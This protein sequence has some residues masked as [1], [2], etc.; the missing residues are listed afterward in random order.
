MAMIPPLDSRGLLPCGIHEAT[1]AEVQARF[2]YNPQRLRLIENARDFAKTR[3]AP[4][5]ALGV[6][7]LI[8]AGSTFSDKPNPSDIEMTL[9]IQVAHLTPDG[10]QLTLLLQANHDGIKEE[11]GVDFYTTYVLPGVQS[12]V[13]YFQYVG[14]KT[15][16]MKALN[17]KDLRGVIEVIA[18]PHG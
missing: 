11:Q 4:L 7:R 14:E 18:W 6:G 17:N 9:E 5:S 8:I 10:L 12:F 3:L 13:D 16:Q 1:W 15:A 2:A